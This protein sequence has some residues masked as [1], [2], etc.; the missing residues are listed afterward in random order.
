MSDLPDNNPKTR[1]GVTKPNLF[2]VP[3][4]SLIYQ[5]LAMQDGARKYGPY[6]WRGNSVTA[7]IYVAAALRHIMAWMDGEELA[8][9]SQ[10]PHL[11]H[12]LACLG[13]LVDAKETG[14]LI[15]DRPRVGATS[16]LIDDWTAPTVTTPLPKAE[17]PIMTVDL[18]PLPYNAD[19]GSGT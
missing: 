9:D 5:A 1:F 17:E 19:G 16:K 2:L 8:A 10:K 18:S 12:A 6:N 3:P 15:D 7:S 4:A 14:N 11:G 13:I